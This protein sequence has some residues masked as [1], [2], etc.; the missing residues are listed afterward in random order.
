MRGF[1]RPGQYELSAQWTCVFAGDRAL[2]SEDPRGTVDR[3]E[4]PVGEGPLSRAV[5]VLRLLANAGPAGV[6]LTEITQQVGL[7]HATVHRLLKQLVSLRLVRRTDSRRYALGVLTFEF[8]LAAAQSFDLRGICGPDLEQVAA[9]SGHTAYLTVRSGNEA[10]C[11]DRRAGSFPIQVIALNIG[12]RRPLGIGGGGLAILASL[13][14]REREE[15]IDSVKQVLAEKWAMSEAEVHDL[16]RRT[17]RDG[18]ALIHNTITVG[19]SAL[20]VPVRDS[21]NRVVAALSIGTVSSQLSAA[22]VRTLSSL[23]R[24]HALAI[25]ASMRSTGVP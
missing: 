2:T 9:E 25:E 1:P 14:D 10:V 13:E 23:L 24:T 8:G 6:A 15:V 4:K 16:V 19:V 17:R 5:S 7:P 21:L 20:G 12:S 11:V 22:K 18:Y 3:M